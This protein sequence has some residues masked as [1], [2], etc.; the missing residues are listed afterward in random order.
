[1]LTSHCQHC[2]A[3]K[4]PEQYNDN[5]CGGC[6][7]VLTE[8]REFVVREN[9][10]RI[11]TEEANRKII[12]EKRADLESGKL[13]PEQAGLKPVQPVIDLTAALKEA[14]L[15]RA[16]NTNSSHAD[17]R[18]PFDPGLRSAQYGNLGMAAKVPSTATIRP[19]GTA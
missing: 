12:E 10:V 7:A 4:T 13:T 6:Q 18:A 19:E 2:G 1:M 5:Y 16:H 11:A 15:R 14:L 17:P 3:A 9:A 8:T